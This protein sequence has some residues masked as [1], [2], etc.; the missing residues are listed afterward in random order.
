MASN[1]PV[2]DIN[3]SQ[4]LN[5]TLEATEGMAGVLLAEG[6][7]SEHELRRVIALRRESGLGTV[8]VIAKLGLVAER[9]LS[10]A[11]ARATGLPQ[12]EDTDFPDVPVAEDRISVKFLKASNVCPLAETQTELVVALADPEDDY[13]VQALAMAVGKPVAC[14]V[15][16]P[17]Q[18]ER[19]IER[20]Y[21]AQSSLADIV[22]AIDE[23]GLD[24]ANENVERLIDLA[25]ETPVVR[26]VNLII[27]RAIEMRASDIHI[28]PFHNTLKVRYRVDGVLQDAD[29]PPARSTAAVISR[30]KIMAKLNIA[31]RRLPQDGRIQIRTQGKQ[32][33]LRVST[34]PTLH[35]ESVVLRV[36]DKEFV[37]LDFTSLGFLSGGA[38]QFLKVLSQPH[39]ILLVTGPTGSGKTTTLYTALQRLNTPDRKILTV[40]DPVEYQLEGINQIHV[41]PKIDL[42]FANALRSIVRQDPDIIMIGEMRDLETAGIAVQSALTGHLVLSTLHTNDAGSS[43]TRLLDMGVEDYLLTS[44]VNGI[45][46]QR[47]VRKLCSCRQD[48]VPLPE[49]V[50]EWKLER[51]TADD[52]IR[53]F[54]PVGCEVCAGTGY[55]GR[56]VIMEFMPMTDAIRREILG[57]RD[58]TA[59]QQAAIAAGM[60]T[61]KED[62]VA[63]AL[64]GDTTIEEVI[65]VTQD[66][67]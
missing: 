7:I 8:A 13:T 53:L 31:E 33:D 46:A 59:I 27:N 11:I 43:I 9:D 2:P 64:H 40:E 65:R 39:G 35:G 30:I 17:S 60:M 15:A 47:L 50:Q 58:S 28:E 23:S 37:P 49:L 52:K 10:S 54:K 42:T 29:S 18:I 66:T 41:K 67:Q 63:K 26:L 6:L 48:Y 16:T 25:S 24:D 22:E 57:H 3:G 62:G 21:D 5:D 4:P 36:L 32:I 38:Q 20:V 61:M 12:A 51:H 55:R 1:S 45:M 44:T 19:G 34:V 56:T 14:K